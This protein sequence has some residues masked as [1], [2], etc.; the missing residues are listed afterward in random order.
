MTTSSVRDAI[1]WIEEISNRGIVEFRYRD[2]PDELKNRKMLH[3][4]V[5]SDLLTSN[6]K[7]EDLSIWSISDNGK[8]RI[9][10][11]QDQKYEDKG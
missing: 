1:R 11:F 9:K 10:I 2:L 7:E 3:K 8:K 5:S 4:A 6:K